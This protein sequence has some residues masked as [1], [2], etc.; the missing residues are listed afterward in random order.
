MTSAKI[1]NF[2][3]SSKN[4]DVI[5]FFENFFLELK[6]IYKLYLRAKFE[7]IWIN[8]PGV[9][10]ILNFCWRQQKEFFLNFSKMAETEF[11]AQHFLERY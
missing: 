9:I 11:L 4:A 7:L 8:I 10:S 5:N 2:P 3:F 1:S 6:D